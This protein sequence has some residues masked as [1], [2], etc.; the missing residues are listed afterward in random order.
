LHSGFFRHAEQKPESIAVI[1]GSERLTF[2]ALALRAERI[3]M[4]LSE[5]GIGPGEIVAIDAVRS[6]DTVAGL[7]GILKAGAAYLPI[8][9]RLPLSRTEFVLSDC[10]VR[11][12]VAGGSSLLAARVSR[13][14][15]V[16]S[17][18]ISTNFT[19]NTPSQEGPPDLGY[20]MLTSGS[21]GNPKGVMITH[22]AAMNT[23][24]DINDRFAVSQG[25]CILAVSSFAFDLSVYDLFGVLGA[26]GT[27]VLP[28]NEESY[29]PAAWIRLMGEEHV[30]IWNSVPTL[31]ELLLSHLTALDQDMGADLR[32]AFLSGDWISVGLPERLWAVSPRTEIVS[33]GG[34]TE[35]SIWSTYF[36]IRDVDPEWVSIPYGRA[37]TNQHC[38]ILNDQGEH[39]ESGHVGE[40]YIGGAGV[41]AGYLNRPDLT[42]ERFLP[43]RWSNE[44]HATMYRT[45]DYG[46]YRSDGAIQFVGRIDDQIKVNG[47]R[48]EL[49]EIEGR[50]AQCA[51]VGQCAVSTIG[52]SSETRRLIAYIVPRNGSIDKSAIRAHLKNHLPAQMVPGSFV[53]VESLPINANG[54]VDRAKLK[55]MQMLE[56]ASAVGAEKILT[57]RVSRI[58]GEVLHLPYVGPHDDF[59]EL[60]GDSLTAVL[61]FIRLEQEFSNVPPLAALLEHPTVADFVRLLASGCDSREALVVELQP[62]GNRP[63]LFCLP[64]A[65]GQLLV[66]RHLARNIGRDQ[67]LFGIA[68]QGLDGCEP[69]RTIEEMAA[70]GVRELK[71]AQPSGPYRLAGFSAGG[72]I[73]FEMAR[74]LHE[75]GNRVGILLLI[76]S[77]PGLP[78]AP[79]FVSRMIFQVRYVASRPWRELPAYFGEKAKAASIKVRGMLRRAPAEWNLIDGLNQMPNAARVAQATYLAL[80]AYVPRPYPGNA[81]LLRAS[82]Q[83]RVRRVGE[84]MGWQ[85]LCKCG[86]RVIRV[87]GTHSDCLGPRYVASLARTVRMSLAQEEQSTPS[88]HVPRGARRESANG[89]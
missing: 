74:Q 54:K 67:P 55:A 9:P 29:D 70:R 68:P 43:D 62:V 65:D 80:K 64:G 73:A 3:S 77:F 4:A 26:G 57:A 6:A 72:V 82:I 12:A 14:V 17:L 11:Y 42:V 27:I 5:F 81:V 61:L 2:G 37:L 36:Q 8:D 41:A 66:F 45:G 15:D 21:T 30:T 56:P 34:A 69:D 23:I 49:A 13:S 76:D 10:G 38:Y 25:D 88:D 47:Y 28:T 7:L 16:S 84:D 22:S 89:T 20:I 59:F 1:C 31:M 87:C 33:L 79:S 53:A 51:D 86:L 18:Q 71:R 40:L 83:P 85:K 35:A 24:E 48:I 60:G 32:I 63:P 75:M 19:S 39:C 50:L 52:D 78:F 58:W 46:R 44:P